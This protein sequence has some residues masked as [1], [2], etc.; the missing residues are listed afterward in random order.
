MRYNAAVALVLLQADEYAKDVIP[1][2]E[3]TDESDGYLNDSDFHP[4]IWE[5][6]EN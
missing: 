1:I 6:F 5:A 4:F 3:K 2:I